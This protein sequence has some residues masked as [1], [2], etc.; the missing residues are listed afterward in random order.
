M[1]VTIKTI[2]SLAKVST[3]TVSRY[4]N[5]PDSV[6][7]SKR[8]IIAEIISAQNYKRNELA[9][10]LV[11]NQSKTVGVILPDINNIYFS[12]IMLGI[13]HALEEKGY[14]T[15]ICN[16]HGN[17]EKE[18]SYVD[19]LLCHRVAGMIFI[20]TR[21]L[22]RKLNDHVIELAEHLPIVLVNDYLVDSNVN[23]VMNNEARGVE[24]AL[25]Y[26]FDNGHREIGFI[27]GNLPMTT[28][29]YKRNGFQEHMKHLGLDWREYYV[30]EDPY[31]G[32]GYQAMCSMLRQEKHPTAVITANDQMAIGAVRAVFENGF[33][34]P[35]DVSIIGYSNVP[36]SGEIYP[37]LTTVDQSPI[38][39]GETA[40][41]ILISQIHNDR[42][43][44]TRRQ[45]SLWLETEL[46]IRNSTAPRE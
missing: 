6:S 11:M 10:D 4:L 17:I 40:A 35:R 39:T 13:E 23:F 19:M 14:N 2:A 32:G 22:D 31:E 44:M 42:S 3:A 8:R 29:A 15:F 9:R 38:Y 36:I 16:T 30:E 25:Q 1:A 46:V 41:Q 21:P 18:K 12:P 37:R 20:G 27:N 24:K 28:Y 7:E 26:L 43:R 45:M 34:V 33:N 5:N